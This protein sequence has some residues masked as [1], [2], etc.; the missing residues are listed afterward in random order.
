MKMIPLMVSLI[1]FSMCDSA[2]TA[3]PSP[4]PAD[5]PAVILPNGTH[6]I[7]EVA[8]ND[9]SRAAGLMYRD[10]LDRDRGMLFLFPATGHY[11]FWMK[12]TLIPLDM[13]WIDEGRRI[14]HIKNDVPP[15]RADPCTSYAPGVPAR[16][17]LE[18]AAGEAA[19]HRLEV[20]NMLTFVNTER[21]TVR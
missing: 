9:E 12:N 18:V 8:A 20:G 6:V 10:R 15:C 16:S 3:P 13:I 19:R 21:Y 7:V 11:P 2:P 5:L 4:N 1:L 14:V 17:V